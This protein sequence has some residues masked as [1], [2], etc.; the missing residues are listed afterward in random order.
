MRPSP[1]IPRRDSSQAVAE[2][3]APSAPA[4]S[5][6]A[7]TVASKPRPEAAIV[8][9][10]LPTRSSPASPNAATNPPAEGA[11]RA[12]PGRHASAARTR[13]P[14]GMSSARRAPANNW[15]KRVSVP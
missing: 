10:P 7:A 4:T 12:A 9:A 1:T 3:G 2:P 11:I 13:P 15:Y 14:A 6:T 8:T 5:D